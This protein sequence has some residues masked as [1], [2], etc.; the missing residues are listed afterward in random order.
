VGFYFQSK[1]LF[2]RLWFD[3]YMDDWVLGELYHIPGISKNEPFSRSG[4]IFIFNLF[5]IAGEA[6]I[7]SMSDT[8]IPLND[9]VMNL[10]FPCR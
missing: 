5:L 4:Y 8:L 7:A 2:T 1:A 6:L 3:Y 10:D 9:M